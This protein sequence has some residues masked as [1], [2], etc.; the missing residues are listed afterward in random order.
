LGYADNVKGYRLW[1]PTAHKVVVS[2]DVTFAKNELQSKQANDSFTKGA[3]MLQT[4]KKP[5]ND[6]VETEQEQEQ[7]EPNEASNEGL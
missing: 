3:T 1:D 7:Q 5:S 2:R 4:E 6:S